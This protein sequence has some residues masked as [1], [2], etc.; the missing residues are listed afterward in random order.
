M[1]G[2]NGPP[3]IMRSHLLLHNDNQDE[4]IIGSKIEKPFFYFLSQLLLRIRD[5]GCA[6]A[7]QRECDKYLSYKERKLL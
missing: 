4:N 7:K 6:A 5:F 3:C 1:N 2:N